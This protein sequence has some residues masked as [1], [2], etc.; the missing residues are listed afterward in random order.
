MSN[1][2]FSYTHNLNTLQIKSLYKF[3]KE[4]PFCVAECDKN[5]GLIIVENS[6]YDFLCRSLLND[7][8]TYEI[9]NSD[10][11]TMINTNIKSVVDELVVNKHLSKKLGDKLLIKNSILGSFRILFKIHKKTFGLRPIIN[12]RNHPL[13]AIALLLDFILQIF[14]KESDS[15]IQDSQNLIQLT[16]DCTFPSD[17][18]I[19]SSDFESLFTNIDLDHALVIITSFIADNFKCEEIS[20]LAFNK[21]LKCVFDNNFFIYGNVFR[22]QRRGVAM[23]LKC[24]P[25]IANMYLSIIEKSFLTIN[26][27]PLYKRFVDDVLTGC[28]NDF[29][30]NILKTHFNNLNLNI[31]TDKTVVFLDL[32]IS[33]NN[34]TC[35]LEFSMYLKTTNTFSYLINSSNH[36]DSIFNNIP[37]S[38]FFRARRICSNLYDYY[39]F[40]R[41]FRFQLISRGYSTLKLDKACRMV[42]NLNRNEIIPYNKRVN[43]F[44]TDEKLF[45]KIPFNFNFLNLKSF[46]H[47]YKFT[48]NHLKNCNLKLINSIEPNISRIFVHNFKLFKPKTFSF[49]KCNKKSCKHCCF[50]DCNSYVKLKKFFLPIQVN[51]SCISKN[52]V[53]ILY[54]NI[55]YH[56]YIGQTKL[57]K[58]RFNSHKRNIRLMILDGKTN[59]LINHFN[60]EKHSL[61]NIK[62]FIFKDNIDIL[63]ERLNIELQLIHLFLKLGITLLNEKIPS[64]YCHKKFLPLFNC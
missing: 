42:A 62:F 13:E 25:A 30:M 2:K 17:L 11:L 10:P 53:Y 55:C 32:K 19:S 33:L 7:I 63:N 29:D 12:C 61:K 21:L 23:G 49:V 15:Y 8:N 51:S 4:K 43:S 18:K 59:I 39:Y 57:F 37:K 34:L 45:F 44:L 26:K 9:I 38:I 58:K 50:A 52:L 24:A 60:Q 5:V 36:P 1:F 14:V 48:Q 56:F 28:N 47:N 31:V 35:R 16:K 54:C 46:F 3:I 20:T 40:T 41:I 64:I 22:R 6:K 27:P